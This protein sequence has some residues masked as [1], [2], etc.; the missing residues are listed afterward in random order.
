ML[1]STGSQGSG[2]GC[3]VLV[4]KCGWMSTIFVSDDKHQTGAQD[5]A[6]AEQRATAVV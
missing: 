1:L 2:V 3:S 4:V 5:S 6:V